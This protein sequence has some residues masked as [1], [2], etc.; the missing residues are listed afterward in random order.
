MYAFLIYQTIHVL[1][2]WVDLLAEEVELV[3]GMTLLM[4]DPHFRLICLTL[5]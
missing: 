5:Y 3:R 4:C 1:Q 2:Q